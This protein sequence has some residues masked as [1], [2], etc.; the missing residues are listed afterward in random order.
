MAKQK[1]NKQKK[2]LRFRHKVVFGF[3]RGIFRIHTKIKY[4]YTA[5]KCTLKPPFLMLC[6]H[7]TT[8]DPIFAVMSF[9]C[10]IYYCA[11]D[12]LF[13]MKFI[14]PILRYLV[15]PIPKKKSVVDLQAMRDILRVIRE[16]GAVGLFPEGN[17]ILS[18]SQWPIAEGIAKLVK[19]SKVPLVI[20]NIEGG[21]GADPR[22]GVSKRKGK[23]RGV[24]RKVIMPDEYKE[25][26]NA[27]LHRI[28]CDNLAVNDAESGVKFKSE[29]R[30]EN[31]ERA[32]YMCPHCGGISTI[33]SKGVHFT[34]RKCGAQWEYTEDLHIVPSD[35][36]SVVSEWYNWEKQEIAKL[37][38]NTNT[39]GEIL[40]DDN[41]EFYQS[42]RFK[43]KQK[44]VG[45]KIAANSNG[46]AVY[47]N[48]VSRYFP[49]DQIDGVALVHRNK[50]DFYYQGE[51]Y[52]VK[53]DDRFC[54]IKYVHL[55]EG[56]KN[57]I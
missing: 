51:T 57:K 42:I 14:S 5:E 40:S 33:T 43:K 46:I 52:Q 47:S 56:V 9:K 48:G 13:N 25:M 11:M 26:D 1:Q 21:Y 44:L 55:F 54:S 28:I 35:R 29:H 10:P 41:I 34:C 24:I 30:A 45:D 8:F 6:N 7:V 2:W 32:L 18:G 39:N 37:A 3:F 27:S 49:F 12:D 16:G 22:W 4:N 36:F 17:R 38:A 20:Y 15:A 31:I 50:F 53:G 23:M 19:I